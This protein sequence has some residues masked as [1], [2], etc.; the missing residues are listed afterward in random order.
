MM[1]V[2]RRGG[3]FVKQFLMDAVDLDARLNCRALSMV[4]N[5]ERL[6]LTLRTENDVLVHM[7]SLKL[8]DQLKSLILDFEVSLVDG[9][10]KIAYIQIEGL[11]FRTKLRKFL[12]FTASLVLLRILMG[13]NVTNN[14]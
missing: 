10:R 2:L 11:Q 13:R 8:Y 1:C 6:K 14:F 4:P 5:V 9:K 12:C 3:K 7:V